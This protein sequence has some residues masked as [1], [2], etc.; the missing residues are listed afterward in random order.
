M[1]LVERA[2]F[3]QMLE[4]QRCILKRVQLQVLVVGQDKDDVWTSLRSGVVLQGLLDSIAGIFQGQC[5]VNCKQP[6][7]G[8]QQNRGALHDFRSAR[9]EALVEP[10]DRWIAAD[11]LPPIRHGGW[12]RTRLIRIRCGERHP[13]SR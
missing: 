6:R 4:C 5:L 3:L 12:G 13:P 9:I 11:K 7:E 8:A 10:E 1:V 2:L